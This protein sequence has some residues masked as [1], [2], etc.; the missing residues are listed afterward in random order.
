MVAF[1]MFGD[2]FQG[3]PIFPEKFHPFTKTE[4]PSLARP[5]TIPVG[6]SPGPF[7]Q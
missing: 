3:T 4:L 2:F 7:R 5:V 1:G 6:L